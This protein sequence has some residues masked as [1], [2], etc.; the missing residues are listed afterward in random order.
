L[1]KKAGLISRRR[2]RYASKTAEPIIAIANVIQQLRIKAQKVGTLK[3]TNEQ[4]VTTQTQ[5]GR[6]VVTIASPDPSVVYVPSY[7]PEVV[8]Y[9]PPAYET[10]AGARRRGFS[11]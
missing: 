9:P 11:D 4:V 10:R 5:D 6:E 8:Y 7:N 3:T 1:A 2:N